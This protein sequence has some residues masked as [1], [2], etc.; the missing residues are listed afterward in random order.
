[1]SLGLT[2]LLVLGLGA[3]PP[4][5]S[6]VELSLAQ[7]GGGGHPA[8]DK[9]IR[10]AHP[11]GW[12]GEME[13]DGRSIRLFGGAGEMLIAVVSHPSQLDP[14][15]QLLRQRHPSVVPSPPQAIDVPGIDAQRGER[16]TRFEFTGKELGE[17]VTV[18]RGGLIVLF[19]TIV[20]PN[21]WAEVAP[22]V[23]RCYPTVEVTDRVAKGAGKALGPK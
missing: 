7:R 20:A 5:V 14:H 17:M 10:V 2:A 23:A 15:M 22:L 12:S 13:S 4:V 16:A 19:A 1:M 18:E 9:R 11:Q 21:A 3:S 8:L 6:L